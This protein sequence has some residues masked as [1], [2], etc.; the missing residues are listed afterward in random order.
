M[1]GEERIAVYGAGAVGAYVGGYMTRDGRDV[2]LIDPWEAHVNL[3]RDPGLKLS[4]LTEPENFQVKCNAVL[5]AD[6]PPPGDPSGN[7]GPFD[8]IFIC[9]KSFDTDAAAKRMKPY[10][11]D[12]GFMVS[13]QN[14]INEGTIADVVGKDKT[15]GC[16]ASAI[17]VSMWEPGAVRRNVKLGGTEHIVF[18]AGELDG[19]VTPRA[20]RIAE[21]LSSIDSAKVT[22]TLMGERW[23][24]LI[25]NCM[26]NPIS[27]A[28]GMA[29]NACDTDDHIRRLGIRIG[30]ESIQVAMAEG[31][32]LEKILGMPPEQ[33]LAAGQGDAD[34][35]AACDKKLLDD[36]AKRSDEQRPSM[37][38][39]MVKGRP[40]EIDFING[41]VVRSA[42][43]HGIAVPANAG[44][45]AA[46]KAIEAGKMTPS[47][48]AIADI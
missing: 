16:I 18:R 46:I 11:A 2:T 8:V 45:V 40:T 34:A 37:A 5:D 44:I 30:A 29:S 14:G 12:D 42:E 25:V 13:L 36:R 48:E 28:S 33:I 35:M 17:S 27:A 23:S 32:P 22:E 39:D 3:M 26:R 6:L 10:L 1:A 24:K 41:F 43:A 21:I 4:G 9:V 19:S 31:Y 38:Q 20:R 47:P 7:G 15:M